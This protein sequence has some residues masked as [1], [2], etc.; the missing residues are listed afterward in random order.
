M[1]EITPGAQTS[2]HA[3][4]QKAD[5]WSNVVIGVGLALDL[6]PPIL[7]KAQVAFP[8]AV[9]IGTALAVLGLVAKVW[10]AIGYGRNRSAVKAAALSQP[11]QE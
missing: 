7:E 2:E 4:A 6:L 8:Q 11:T 10:N 1:A 9:W 3:I 5:L